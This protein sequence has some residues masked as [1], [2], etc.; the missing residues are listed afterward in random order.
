MT[1]STTLA[2]F[3]LVPKQVQVK[4]ESIDEANYKSDVQYEKISK[5][6]EEA[7]KKMKYERYESKIFLCIHA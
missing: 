6:K 5:P 1:M 2:C 7:T 4:I 3:K